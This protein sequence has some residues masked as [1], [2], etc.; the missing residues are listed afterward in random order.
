MKEV[1][2][3]AEDCL[4]LGQYLNKKLGNKMEFTSGI[5]NDAIDGIYHC[6]PFDSYNNFSEYRKN[7][8]MFNFKFCKDRFLRLCVENGVYPKTTGHKLAVLSD[9]YE[10]LYKRFGK[11]TFFC[12][13]KDNPHETLFLQWSFTNRDE[14]IQNLKNDSYFD[15]AK[16]DKLI[17]IGESTTQT[18]F[19]LN[20]AMKDYLSKMI[21]LPFELI[22][23][24]NENIEDFIKYKR[25]RKIPTLILNEDTDILSERKR[26]LDRK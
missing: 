4:K 20:D 16:I 7:K 24:V 11:P 26:I 25:G 10:V 1:F 15:D 17:I 5:F 8:I 13:T 23:F 9:F 12:T 2:S 18:N 19:Q 14:D 22:G 3:K 6:L 21:G